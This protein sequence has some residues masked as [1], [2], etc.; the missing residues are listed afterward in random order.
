[1][2]RRRS[3]AAL[4]ALLI[5]AA[6]PAAAAPALA[7][8]AGLSAHERT[9]AYWTPARMR[10]AVP[11]D[12]VRTENGTFK[13]LAR[14]AP[15]S[16]GN[17]AGSSWPNGKGLVYQAVGKVWFHMD[18][19]D[20]IC[21]G[22][23]VD[24]GS[25]NANGSSLV[26]TAAHCAYDEL[27]DEF[28]TSWIFI[29]QFDS[30]PT[31]TCGSTAYGCWTGNRLVVHDGYASREAFDDEA[32]WHDFAVVRVGP[33][34]KSGTAELDQVIGDFPITFTSFATNTRMHA[35]GYPA[36]QKYKG[37]DLTYCAGPVFYDP[38]NDQKTYG[39]T[40]N[41]TGGSSGGPWFSGFNESTGNTGTL[42]S[43]NSYGYSGVK[44]MH[45]PKFNANTQAVYTT[46]KTGTGNA[47]A[48]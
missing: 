10:A 37:N 33:G 13:P 42:S 26:L 46:A 27:N 36:S 21:S 17:T 24:D 22:A 25:A 43:L 41:M 8:G 6:L 31:Y 18:G 12:F 29:P 19:G 44:A 14:P 32:T 16:G 3:A 4:A 35:F 20:W 40:C 48:N 1:M 2:S 9:L 47:I 5:L 30:Q 34:G 7:G 28:A 38:Y 39:M 11:R 23:I 15:G 45:G